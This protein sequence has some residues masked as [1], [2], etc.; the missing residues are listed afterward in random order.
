MNDIGLTSS[1]SVIKSACSSYDN[2]RQSID[3]SSLI[4]QSDVSSSRTA[5]LAYD[6]LGSLLFEV[7]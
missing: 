5:L 3:S 1:P 2:N 4:R 7:C 6:V